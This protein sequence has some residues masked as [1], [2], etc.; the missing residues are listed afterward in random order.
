M[1]KIKYSM[2]TTERQKQ[3]IKI[4]L[5]TRKVNPLSSSPN[6]LFST[7]QTLFDFFLKGG[8]KRIKRKQWYPLNGDKKKKSDLAFLSFHIWIEISH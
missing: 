4:R 5:L 2:Y 7:N 1:A 6:F 3:F 8:E